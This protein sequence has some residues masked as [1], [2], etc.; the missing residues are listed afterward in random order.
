MQSEDLNDILHAGSKL[1]CAISSTQTVTS[2][3]IDP[4]NFPKAI[5]YKNH[6]I[7][8][9]HDRVLSGLIETVDAKNDGCLYSLSTAIIKACSFLF[10]Y[11]FILVFGGVS[12]AICYDGSSFFVFDSHSRNQTGTSCSDGTAVLG[13]AES[14]DELCIFINNLV[15]SLGK[16][17]HN[18]Q[19]DLHSYSFSRKLD[20]DVESCTEILDGYPGYRITTLLKRKRSKAKMHESTRSSINTGIDN[21]EEEVLSSPNRHLSQIWHSYAKRSFSDVTDDR[22]TKRSF[23]DV[24]D[25]PNI[26]KQDKPDKFIS[27]FHRLVSFGPDYVCSCC[28]QTFFRHNVRKTDNMSLE[29]RKFCND[30]W[31]VDGC[32]WVCLTCWKA[33]KKG[34]VPMFWLHNGLKFPE[35]PKELELSNLEERLVSPRLPFMQLHAMPRGGQLSLRGNVVNVP[36]D[37]NSTIKSLPR[38]MCDNETI[39]VKLKRK[40]SYKHHVYFENVRPNQV[41]QAAQ[42]LVSNSRLFQSEGIVLN[43]NWLEQPKELLTVQD[44]CSEDVDEVSSD[45]EVSRS[46]CWTEDEHF[47]DRPTG[48]FDTCLQSLDFR[49]FNQILC[50]APGENN[51]PLGIFQ[52]VHSE[53][54]SF[55]GIF[56]GQT[57]VDN[58]NRMVPLH[59]SAICKW[60]LR[61]I[62]R[63]VATCIPN[64]FYKLKKLQIKQ[65][66]DKVSLSVRKC[67]VKDLLLTAGNLLSPGFVDQLTMQNDG[68][69]VLRTLRGSPPYWEQAKRDLFA[70]IRQIG[71][72]TWFCSF[73]A[74]ETKW[75]PL[76]KTLTKLLRGIDITLEEASKLSWH[77]KS[78]LIKSDPVTCARYFDYRVQTFIRDVLK[79][80]SSPVGEIADFFY[81]VEFQQ[82]GSPH[83]HMLIWVKNPLV[84][85]RDS[86][87]A[88]IKFVDSFVTCRR[89]DSMP[90]LINLQTHRHAGTCRKHGKSV[91]RF[92]FPIFPLP[93][94]MLLYPLQPSDNTDCKDKVEK[95]TS[96]LD[97]LYKSDSDMGFDNF[98]SQLN[99]NLEEY[100]NIIRS[101]LKRPQLFLKRSISESRI[102]NYNTVLLKSWMAN[103]DLQY[104]LDPYSCVSYIVSYIS[105]GQR[106]L[107]K[108]LHDACAEAQKNSDIKQ[109]VRKIGNQFLSSVEIGAQEAVYLVLQMPLRKCTRDVIYVDTSPPSM[110]TSLIKPYSQLKE[111]P[112]GSRDVEMDSVLKR[113]KRRPFSMEMLCYADFATWYDLYYGLKKQVETSGPEELPEIEYELDKEDDIQPFGSVAYENVITFPCGTRL[114]KRR[115]QKVLYTNMT[116]LNQ[117]K[118]EHYRQNLMLYT[119]WRN[120]VTDLLHGVMTYEDSYNEKMN[121]ITVNKLQYENCALEDMP[122]PDEIEDTNVSSTLNS[123]CEFQNALDVE[124]GKSRA[125]DFGYFD[126]GI[127]ASSHETYD[128]GEDIGA[129][130]RV[131]FEEVLPHKEIDNEHFLKQVRTL[132]KDQKLFFSTILANVKT[133]SVP[134]YTFLSGGAGVGKSVVTRCIYQALLKYYNHMRNEN[135]DTFKLLLCAPTGKAAHNIGGM[136]IHSAFG[137]PANQGFSFKPLDMQQ[138]NSFRARYNSLRLVIIDEISMVG[139]SMFN[140]MNL[141]LQEIKGCTLPFGGVSILAVGD[142]FQLKPVMDSWI[143]SQTYSYPQIQCLA[144]NLWVDLFNFYELTTVM[145]QKDDQ[146]FAELLNRLREGKHTDADIQTLKRQVIDNTKDVE[147]LPHLFCTRK[148]SNLHNSGVLNRLQDSDKVTIDA[149]DVVSGDLSPCIQH[150]VLSKIPDDASISMGL[151]KRLTL[152]VNLTGEMCVNILTDDG[153]TN[154]AS[155]VIKKFDFRVPQ[156][157]RC[158]IVWVQFD[159]ASIG[160][161]WRTRY[162]HLYT[163]DISPSW[164]PVLETS[165]RFCFQHYKKYLITRRQFPLALSAGKTIHKAQGS[166]MTA[167]ALHFGKKKIDHIHYVGLS[168]VT[169]LSQVHI[170][171][172][173]ANKISVSK[174]VEV[175][176]KRLR[177]ERKMQCLPCLESFG[178]DV[179]KVCFHNCRSLS[180]HFGDFRHDS[181]LMCADLIGLVETRVWDNVDKALEIDGFKVFFAER[182]HAAHGLVVYYRENLSLE[183]LCSNTVASVEY[184]LFDINHDILVCFVYCPPKA[185]TIDN[186]SHFLCHID[187]IISERQTSSYKLLLMGDFNFDFLEKKS[188]AALFEKKYQLAQIVHS[189]TTDYGTCLDHIYT[190]LSGSSIRSSGTLESYYSDHKP[191]F[192]AYSLQ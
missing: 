1:Y 99:M 183:L 115:Q 109:Q 90:D 121:E 128:I 50:L 6:R 188:L 76:L 100:L 95:I 46:E 143:F 160:E 174:E 167:A 104:V 9:K 31:S 61:N 154:G 80:H 37:V 13:V 136:T 122:G 43:E 52:D 53:I 132:N 145:R 180:T 178:A 60:E 84:H 127:A 189:V 93:S 101:T 38:M 139:R 69:R 105:K 117:D 181:N 166:T 24:T 67:K 58:S 88:V 39:M 98:L 110:R 176:M 73:S 161:K 91:C 22:N 83:I 118:E 77:E 42:W 51:V 147:L 30:I 79:H 87:S 162:R 7:F 40:L 129:S 163:N 151:H 15:M 10:S 18:E 25:D 112:S 106:G 119:H 169:Q 102:N 12:V 150:S 55:P 184:C 41:F 68:Y 82:R 170:T 2:D 65:I 182:V 3:Y 156:S 179:M 142:L 116:T 8:V 177:T 144:P 152:G 54:L 175:E 78:Q 26:I 165:R 89:D 33:M 72:P 92:N 146:C 21:N 168:R 149:I 138:L 186:I 49:E 185:A 111:L 159:D 171:E 157:P 19:F 131:L 173:N 123:E 57:R 153:L 103:M 27:D 140:Y 192:C 34:K 164:T 64:I 75:E 126:P 59:Y 45:P 191:L 11:H 56:C 70:M 44:D 172:L 137:I 28:T 14:L 48:N 94:T 141:R 5:K 32:E 158:S 155:C 135:P 108:M 85:G 63:R 66:R 96:F 133:T 17:P 62:D 29:A 23:L 47:Y 107:S 134:F 124:V 190:N 20:H 125:E 86:D 81:R 35:K 71:I 16:Q 130:T 120:E 114:R 74:A 97:A 187:A 148:E 4:E 36:A 113:Y